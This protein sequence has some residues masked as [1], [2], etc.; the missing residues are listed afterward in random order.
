MEMRKIWTTVLLGEVSNC[1]LLNLQQLQHFARCRHASP[2]QKEAFCIVCQEVILWDI[3]ESV[4]MQLLKFGVEWKRRRWL[5]VCGF[6]R[7]TAMCWLWRGF[8]GCR[9][10]TKPGSSGFTSIKVEA[11][12]DWILGERG[13]ITIRR[14]RGIRS[15]QEI[16]HRYWPAGE[17]PAYP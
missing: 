4:R 5:D 15:T 1:W 10:K 11:A 17:A 6:I 16:C 8:M 12:G 3:A 2:A 7:G 9:W 14:I 13:A